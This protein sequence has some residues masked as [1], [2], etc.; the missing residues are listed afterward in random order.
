ME[1]TDF[2]NDRKFCEECAGY[3]PY[4]QSLDASYCANCGGKVRLFS[5]DDWEAFHQSLKD[6]RPK[7]GRPAKNRGN[8]ESA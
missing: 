3:V 4:L 6:R 8:K 7:G 5:S 2:Y 1:N